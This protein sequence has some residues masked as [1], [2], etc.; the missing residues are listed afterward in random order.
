MSLLERIHLGCDAG[1]LGRNYP[2]NIR[3]CPS[4][5]KVTAASGPATEACGHRFTPAGRR[6]SSASMESSPL[7]PAF[8]PRGTAGGVPVTFVSSSTWGEL[9]TAL[10]AR[11]RAFADAAGFEP[12]RR[13]LLL[14]PGADGALAGVLFGLEP[15]DDPT[16]DL[17][18]PGA[19]P[20]LLPAGTYRFAN[21]PHDTRLAALAFALGT[22]RFARYR[23]AEDKEVR[24]ELPDDVDGDELTR[25]A[26][27]VF[28][29]RD[30]INTPAN[31]MGPPELEDAARAL[32]A[33]H[34]ASVPRDRRRRPAR[35]ELPAH[36]RG[37]PRRRPRAAPDRHD[38]G[39]SGA[40]EGHA[41]RQ[42]RV[43]RHRRARHQARRRH[44]QHEEGHG[45]R[46][47]HAG[48]RAHADGARHQDPAA[49]AD[50]GGRERDLRL[51][52]PAARHLSLAQGHHGRDRQHRRRGPA[53][54]GR[55]A[56]ARRRGGARADRRHGDADRRRAR[57]ARPR[58]GAVLHRR[59]RARRRARALRR[60]ART[61]R[62]GGCRC[63]GPTTSCSIPRSPTSTT[64]RAAASPARSPP[65]CS[66][67]AS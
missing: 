52:L 55:R 16:Q 65:R 9:R 15:A 20:G 27:G 58:G 21:A 3:R 22:Y 66:C 31:D 37:R 23:K 5:Q 61:I 45:R 44:A 34:G 43:L 32:A 36:P 50:P 30:L 54:P 39:R 62:S 42:G 67:A 35:G 25:I 38:L 17:F 28:L 8:A 53:D 40:S 41:G 49:R 64:S 10:D 18:R 4:G 56:G 29:A 63:G 48:A 51:R 24:L 47:L 46:R 26:E 33:R 57:R 6:G 2:S 59:R 19:L 13:P 7:H 11:Q 14:L 12:R 1:A 60:R